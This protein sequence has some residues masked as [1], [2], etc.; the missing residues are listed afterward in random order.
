MRRFSIRAPHSSL[1]EHKRSTLLKSGRSHYFPEGPVNVW[2]TTRSPLR[3]KRGDRGQRW[4][5]RTEKRDRTGENLIQQGGAL[6]TR[7]ATLLFLAPVLSFAGSWSGLLVDS[8]CYASQLRNTNKDPSTV[9]RDMNTEV[10]YCVPNP[11]TK[12][13]A[14]VLPDWDSRKLDPSGNTKAAELVRQAG[15]KSLLEVTVTGD[16]TKD[17]IHV[18]SISL[19]DRGPRR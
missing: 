10:R 12:I 17:V 7:F 13:F 6:T 9:E 16:L 19:N 2:S 15:K 4:A 8:N 14:V 11:H 18:A 5:S 1:T 3:E